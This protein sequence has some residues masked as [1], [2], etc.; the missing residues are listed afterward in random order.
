MRVTVHT[1]KGTF[2]GKHSP[3]TPTEKQ[4]QEAKEALQ[5]AA[6]NASYFSLLTDEGIVVLGGDLLKNA[7]F[8]LGE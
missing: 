4:I 1:D 8:V 2:V 3:N 6:D 5:A 7:V